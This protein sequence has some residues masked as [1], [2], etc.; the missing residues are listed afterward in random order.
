MQITVL[1][2]DDRICICNWWGCVIEWQLKGCFFSRRLRNSQFLC[3]SFALCHSWLLFVEIRD[4]QRARCF[5][6]RTYSTF[7]KV[8][9]LWLGN[10][11]DCPRDYVKLFHS[12]IWLHLM[13]S[14]YCDHLYSDLHPGL[15]SLSATD[16]MRLSPLGALLN[17]ATLK[18]CEQHH[19]P[20]S[21]IS[22]H[23]NSSKLTSMHPKVNASFR[24]SCHSKSSRRPFPFQ[25]H[26]YFPTDCPLCLATNSFPKQTRVSMTCSDNSHPPWNAPSLL[27]SCNHPKVQRNTCECKQQVT[28][29][30]FLLF[31]LS[32]GTSNTSM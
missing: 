11:K 15:F 17:A 18:G 21:D 19:P 26:G 3:N 7:S 16:C 27:P 24:F 6:W 5:I 2:C 14:S 29:W 20:G 22:T 25:A 9:K 23:Q 30:C 28:L 31:P 8:R 13:C 1:M 10:C 4:T 12:N 32:V